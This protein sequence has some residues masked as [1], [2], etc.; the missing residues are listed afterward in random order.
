MHIGEKIGARLKSIGMTKAEFARRVTSVR[1]NPDFVATPQGAGSWIKTGRIDKGWLSSIAAV[2]DISVEQLIDDV[3]IGQPVQ[4]I[5][6]KEPIPEGFHVV[7]E[8]EIRLSCGNGND[9]EYSELDTTPRVYHESFFKNNKVKPEDVARLSADGQS[10]KPLIK[11][12]YRVCINKKK[13]DVPVVSPKD[14]EDEE[15][16]S[17]FAFLDDGS[18][19]IKYVYID[20]ETNELV[21]HSQN[22]AFKDDRYSQEYANQYIRILGKVIDISGDPNG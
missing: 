13:T 14:A 15:N 4:A 19:K 16:L 17:I 12:G 1:N 11:H 6:D 20:S 2:F 22:K 5:S 10:M 7:H 8:Y 9:I 18:R 21:L 3:D